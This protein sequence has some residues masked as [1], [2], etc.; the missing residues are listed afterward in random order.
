M[1]GTF[2][3][4]E[5]RVNLPALLRLSRS[6]SS[7]SR[8]NGQPDGERHRTSRAEK[9]SYCLVC[10]LYALGPSLMDIFLSPMCREVVGNLM[11]GMGWST[12]GHLFSYLYALT[13][14]AYAFSKCGSAPFIGHLSDRLG[15]RRTLSFTLLVTG[16][17]LLLTG[18]CTTWLSLLLC[19]LFTGLF[20]NGGLLTAY[21]ADIAVSMTDRTSLFSYFIT[22]WAFA[23]VFAAY[24]FP[25]VGENIKVCCLSAFACEVL[26]ALIAHFTF[27]RNAVE[28]TAPSV[29]SLNVLTILRDRPSF[30]RAFRD[31]MKDKLL[32]RLFIT[33]LLTPRIDVAAYLWQKFHEGPS[34]VGYIKAIESMTVILVPLT[35]AISI[36]SRNLGY[37]GT[38]VVCSSLIACCWIGI[39]EVSTMS[40]LYAMVFVRSLIHTIYEPS[41]KSI[42]MESARALKK[43]E[44]IGS[45]AGLQQ[46][47]KGAA[48]VMGSF[49]GSYLA[50]RS[51]YTPLYLSC[52][53]SVAN[54]LVIYRSAHN[55]TDMAQDGPEAGSL[56]RTDKRVAMVGK[57][58]KKDI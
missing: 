17:C 41:T 49:W 50:S 18:H 53:V 10:F 13:L 3:T 15:R 32:F 47:M 51:A 7:P 44:Q 22:S 11:R 46:T 1:L 23:R 25:I 28:C 36:L 21:A 12:D 55:P 14:S 8:A 19:R 30:R 40:Q 26:A 54:A 57:E 37:T 5:S 48:Q 9:I 27:L 6:S 20:A 34:A 42:M 35:P 33:S 58:P 52:I 16:I 45:F 4:H 56:K 24:I 29:Q 38:A 2:P 43:K 39:V 31:M